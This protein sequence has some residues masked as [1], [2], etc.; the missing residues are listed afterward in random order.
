MADDLVGA[1][2]VADADVADELGGDT[3][4]VTV[5]VVRDGPREHAETTSAAS[6]KT[7]TQDRL[8]TC[9]SGLLKFTVTT[10]TAVRGQARA[11]FTGSS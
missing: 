2:L 10:H 11:P 5:L 8:W 1:G 7:A 3:V 4:R 6:A 9:T